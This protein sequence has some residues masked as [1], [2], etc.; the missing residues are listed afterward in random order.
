MSMAVSR[1][2]LRAAMR[3]LLVQWDLA[4]AQWD[5]PVSREF[6]SKYLRTLEPKAL[7]AVNAMEKMEAVLSRARAECG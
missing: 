5:D 2:R 3:D 6:E 4:R 1:A 7:R